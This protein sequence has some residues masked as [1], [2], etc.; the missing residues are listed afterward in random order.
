MAKNLNIIPECYVDTLLLETIISNNKEFNH[1][2][3][4]NTVAKRMKENLNDKFALGVIDNDKKQVAYMS[5][6]QEITSTD[7]LK[8][9]KHPA[10]HHFLILVSPAADSLILNA[11]IEKDINP[12][13]YNLP[14]DLAEFTD[15]TKQIIS[16]ENKDLK[17]F[18]RQL[19][20]A[21]EINI[22]KNWVEYLDA[23]PYQYD[24]EKLKSISVEQ[25]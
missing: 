1:Q 6:F 20:D 22:L 10:K 15:I 16:K 17:K 24:I 12:E 5:E 18:I 11:A 8:L 9:L 14:S 19:R 2:K 25:E 21:K 23:N 13:D 4:C 3:G 7:S